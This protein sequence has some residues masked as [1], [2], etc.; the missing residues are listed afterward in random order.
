MNTTHHR[1]TH[2]RLLS[3]VLTLFLAFGSLV[4]VFEGILPVF[5]TE[6]ASYTAQNYYDSLDESKTGTA[7]RSQLASLITSTHTKQTSYSDL[8]WVFE[9]A[10]AD[11]DNPGNILWFYTGTSV[12]FNGFG[13]GTGSTNR[14]HVWP[15]NGGNAF[16]EKSGPG[17][18]AHH[19][20]PT[21]QQLNSTR[22]S[23]SFGEVPQTTANIVKENNKTNY[24]STAD[25]LCYS[26]NGL[27]YPAAGYRGATARI[28]MYMQV[29][30]GD[31][32]NLSFVLGAGSNKTIGDIETL[33]KWHLEEP[34][35]EQEMA[36]NEAVFAVQGNRNPFIDH[37]E[38]AEMIFCHDGKSYNSTLQAVVEEYGSYLD[39]STG[40][41]GNTTKLT[42]PLSTLTLHE[43]ATY[44]LVPTLTPASD[45]AEYLWVA[46]DP[47][48]ATVN[49]GVVTAVGTGTT[50]VTVYLKTD[51]TVYATVTVKVK[52][53]SGLTVTGTPNQTVYMA[54]NAFNPAGLTVKLTYTDGSTTTLQNKDCEWLDPTS[55]QA[56]LMIGSTSVL[57]RYGDLTA[58]VSGISVKEPTGGTVTIDRTSFGSGGSYAWVPW[59]ADGVSGYAY[60][61][62]GNSSEIQMNSS[63]TSYYIYNSTPIEGGI[64]TIT[65]TD[66]RNSGKKVEIRTSSTPFGQM[67]GAPTTGTSHGTKTVGTDGTTWTIDTTDQYFAI[68]YAD[69]GAFYLDTAEITYGGECTHSVCFTSVTAKPTFSEDG[70]LVKTCAACGEE[71]AHTMPALNTDDY[72]MIDD[73]QFVYTW[74]GETVTVNPLRFYLASVYVNEAYRLSFYV[75]TEVFERLG[76]TSYTVELESVLAGRSAT[77]TNDYTKCADGYYVFTLVGI[78]PDRMVDI[79]TATLTA[80][81]N[82]NTYTATREYSVQRYC[83]DRLA[84]ITDAEERRLLVDLLNYASAAQV[85]TGYQT[86]SLANA[87]LT[88]EARTWATADPRDFEMICDKNYIETPDA[89]VEWQT[90]GMVLT[91][92]IGLYFTVSAES[93]EG[94]HVKLVMHGNEQVI[95]ELTPL[96]DG[97]YR[98]DMRGIG[99]FDLD[100]PIELTVYNGDTAVSNTL[101]Y[102]AASYALRAWADT[103]DADLE[104]LLFALMCLGSR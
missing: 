101:C 77:F 12:S 3:L 19:L 99:L 63:R 26:A 75:P 84:M 64:Q 87:E 7:F 85:Y 94:L 27:F 82:G 70:E 102:S 11:P 67:S 8:E 103:Q 81:V 47:S 68:C 61:Y 35:S 48:V 20:R 52:A 54:G 71:W 10:D 28:L 13:S 72:Q 60:M 66:T 25:E 88:E 95:T 22:G 17:S 59:S 31:T 58:T 4:G 21:E 104:A 92:M 43:D 18:D 14:E 33:M 96:S 91:D 16:P 50:N 74:E 83:Y 89:T 78:N 32:Y 76:V 5:T 100:T 30:W 79:V 6:A 80:T 37:P 62:P 56:V 34:P 46:E 69:S 49:G 39:G 36:R 44:T 9:T 38:Y 29:R 65:L 41:S 2:L 86:D 42:L 23:M 45:A 53:I 98:F 15:K 1:R 57:C 73:V 55:G 24:G 97:T 93:A 40:G 51:L 90:A